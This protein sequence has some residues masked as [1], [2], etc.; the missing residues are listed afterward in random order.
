M[1]IPVAAV[2]FT[3]PGLAELVHVN[4]DTAPDIIPLNFYPGFTLSLSNGQPGPAG[5]GE[6]TSVPVP[7]GLP[8]PAA[9]RG[10]RPF[11]N[12]AGFLGSFELNF[13]TPVTELSMWAFDGPQ[14]FSVNGFRFGQL[15]TIVNVPASPG[16]TSVLFSIN[17]AGGAHVYDR[18][19]INPTPGNILDPLAGPTYFDELSYSTVPGPGTLVLAGA[20]AILRRRRR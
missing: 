2:A 3:S 15:E 1:L 10:L 13:S 6:V 20:A 5:G 8:V 7:P 18:I 11:A 4:F 14:A 16:R 19:V 9:G 12:L 17:P